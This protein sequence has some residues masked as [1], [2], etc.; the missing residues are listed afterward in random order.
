[1][2]HHPFSFHVAVAFRGVLHAVVA[3]ACAIVVPA[4]A[5]AQIADPPKEPQPHASHLTE[6]RRILPADN[7]AELP[8][9]GATATLGPV[10]IGPEDGFLPVP[11]SSSGNESTV[12]GPRPAPRMAQEPPVKC[13][14]CLW[15]GGGMCGRQKLCRRVPGPEGAA[16][17][18]DKQ[19]PGEFPCFECDD[20]FDLCTPPPPGGVAEIESLA[21]FKSGR[22][23]RSNGQHYIGVQGDQLVLRRKCSG[24]AVAT[25]LAADVG[26]TSSMVLAGG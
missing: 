2:N 20:D 1:M 22:M 13:W 3:V 8:V 25:I 21:A 23:L 9:T 16:D 11:V 18:V 15:V 14:G 26:R 17:C 19:L 24:A 5:E 10:G 6:V 7:L 12:P 4:L